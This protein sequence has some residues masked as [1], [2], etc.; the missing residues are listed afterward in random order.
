MKVEWL[1]YFYMAICFSMVGF[2]TLT[3]IALKKSER[4]VV[5]VCDAFS[6]QIFLEL[7]RI[8]DGIPLTCVHKRVLKGKLRRT[9]NLIAFDWAFERICVVHA[10]LAEEYL[11]EMSGVFCGLLRFYLRKN[12]GLAAYACDF[13]KKY[14]LFRFRAMAGL[15]PEVFGL[16]EAESIYCREHALQ[17]I[18]TVGDS[19]L[20]LRALQ[21]IDHSEHFFSG[22]LVSH[23]LRCYEGDVQ[24]L[25]ERMLAEFEQFSP[26]MQRA[27]MDYFRVSSAVCAPFAASVLADASRDCTLRC[28]CIRYLGEY[29]DV[30]AY[31]LLAQLADGS[32]SQKWE[33]CATAS[34]ALG[35]Y[36]SAQAVQ[37]LRGNLHHE[38][39]YI[40]LNAARSLVRLGVS[41]AQMADLIDGNDRYAAEIL[42]Y[43]LSERGGSL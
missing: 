10:D 32:T 15:L 27:L 42:G 40:R 14:R 8:A 28:T 36:R 35:S 43:C 11:F 37:L 1:L 3:A 4:R 9:G 7:A 2:N 39:W 20:V 38:N 19:V 16:L 22:K 17:A 34:S 25:H 6:E 31:P 5:R 41:Y 13:I 18:Y 29:P 12:E 24:K 26:Q 23:G 33:L 21:M 30:S